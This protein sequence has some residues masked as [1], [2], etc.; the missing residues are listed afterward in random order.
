[1]RDLAGQGQ[2]D[3]GIAARRRDEIHTFI[4]EPGAAGVGQLRQY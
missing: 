4:M 2:I 3:G 1:M